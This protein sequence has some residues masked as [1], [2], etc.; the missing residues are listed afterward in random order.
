[1]DAEKAFDKVQNAF[2]IKTVNTLGIGRN[3]FTW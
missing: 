2:L 1:M 3:F